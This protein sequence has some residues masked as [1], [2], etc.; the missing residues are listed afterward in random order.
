MR[1]GAEALSQA[2][3]F[4]SARERISGWIHVP[5]RSIPEMN[6]TEAVCG[7][8]VCAR[9]MPGCRSSASCTAKTSRFALP[10]R[11]AKSDY[12]RKGDTLAVVRLD[13][14]G[15]RAELPGRGDADVS[16]LGKYY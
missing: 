12:A 15:R 10:R 1:D 7:S 3:R 9:L 14:L 8:S 16:H 6:R 5:N 2:T 11:A 4:C 13:R